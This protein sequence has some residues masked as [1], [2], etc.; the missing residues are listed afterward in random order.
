MASEPTTV[1]LIRQALET[2]HGQTILHGPSLAVLRTGALLEQALRSAQ[3][4]PWIRCKD[5][6]PPKEALYLTAS[7][8]GSVQ[9][10][11]WH[12]GAWWCCGMRVGG[13]THYRQMPSPPEAPR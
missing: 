3:A 1:E 6:E 11:L 10:T 12:Q 13:V 4:D 2:L 5:K 7:E 8:D 9:A